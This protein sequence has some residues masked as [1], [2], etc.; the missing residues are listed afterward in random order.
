M[1]TNFLAILFIATAF[2]GIIYFL[3]LVWWQPARQRAMTPTLTL[4]RKQGREERE[5][6]PKVIEYSRS[7]FPILLLVF[8]VR[9]FVFQPFVVPTGSLEPTI[10]PKAFIGVNEFAYGLRWPLNNQKILAIGLPKHGDIILFHDT[11]VPNKDLVKRVIGLP[12]D[13]ISYID[14]VLY[15]N[16]QKADQTAAG[17]TTDGNDDLGP[18]W[19]VQIKHENFLGVQHD[20]YVRPDVPAQNFYNLVVPAGEYFMMGDN[21]DNSEDSRYWGFVPEHNIIGKGW[22]VILSW[23]TKIGAVR[24][25]QVFKKL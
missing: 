20:I 21:R 3:D 10:M 24:W 13:H 11:A 7:F 22:F 4:P 1:N 18:V 5:K 2:S 16:G 19:T 6:I 15:V 8:V 9:A 17:Y 23:N 25:D 12:G 14:K